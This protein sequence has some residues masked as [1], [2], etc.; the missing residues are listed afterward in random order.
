MISFRGS[1]IFCSLMEGEASYTIYTTRGK[2]MLNS[3]G[4]SLRTSVYGL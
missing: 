3:V 2:T 4:S 1:R